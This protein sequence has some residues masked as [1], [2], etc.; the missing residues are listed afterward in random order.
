MTPNSNTP[1]SA[2]VT[3]VLPGSDKPLTA[4]ITFAPK[5][6]LPTDAGKRLQD[7]TLAELAQFA[8]DWE[9]GVWQAYE[10]IKISDLVQ[11]EE[12]SLDIRLLDE[13][14]T[15]PVPSET[16][17]AGQLGWLEQIIILPAAEETAPVSAE[18]DPETAVAATEIED[19]PEPEPVSPSEAEALHEN[20]NV[21]E[22]EPVHEERPSTS[23]NPP[24]TPPAS[25]GRTAGRQR[26]T[27]D[28]AWMAVDI[29]IDEKPLRDMQAHALTSMHR[30][31]AGVLVGARPEKQPD[32]RYIVHI[33]DTVIAKYTVMQGASVTYTPESWRYMNDTV[34]ERYPNETAVI[35]GWYH[36]HPGFGIFLSGMDMFIHQNF[37]TQIWHLAYVLDPQAKTSGFFC[38]DRSKTKV[39]RYDFPWPDW[40]HGSW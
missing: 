1:Y 27:G 10:A 7:C 6:R 12:V 9:R 5:D 16:L 8:D 35:L 18:P 37:F 34:N 28:P 33:I 31:V 22:A 39:Q 24:I 29:F 15:V 32:G 20:I 3:I 38:W 2:T 13:T 26:Q 23:Q 21:S 25:N 4:S 11:K 19:E 30:E 17:P 36:T 40:C 14:A